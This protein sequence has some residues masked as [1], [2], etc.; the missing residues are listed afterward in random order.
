MSN[1]PSRDQNRVPA[2]VKEHT[3][4]LRSEKQN[5]TGEVQD[6]EKIP[7]HVFRDPESKVLAHEADTCEAAVNVKEQTTPSAPKTPSQQ[8]H[9][10]TDTVRCSTSIS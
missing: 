5:T 10:Y 7:A 8:G 3:A 1:C 4:E 9:G 2:P 6:Q